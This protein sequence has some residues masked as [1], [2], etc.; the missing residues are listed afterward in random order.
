MIIYEVNLKISNHIYDNFHIWLQDH[1]AKVLSSKGFLDSK[2]YNVETDIVNY[3][4]L[5]VHYYV[6]DIDSLNNYFTHHASKLREEGL[7]LFSDGF[8]AKRRILSILD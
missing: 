3:K 8:S 7:T 6:K 2:V 1:I 4:L 5:S